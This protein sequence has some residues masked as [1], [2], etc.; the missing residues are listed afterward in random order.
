MAGSLATLQAGDLLGTR[1]QDQRAGA[2]LV[3]TLDA[4]LGNLVGGKIADLTQLGG[5]VTLLDP[6]RGEALHR[7][8]S[9][10]AACFAAPE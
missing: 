6:H 1:G 2:R 3:Q 10:S 5:R 7:R 4:E 8:L 9:Y